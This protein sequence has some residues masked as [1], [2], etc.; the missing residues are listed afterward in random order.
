M[1]DRLIHLR[2]V[3]TVTGQGQFTVICD[4]VVCQHD[5]PENEIPPEDVDRRA[6]HSRCHRKMARKQISLSSPI[7]R[8]PVN[9]PDETS[10]HLTALR[11]CRQ[12]YTEANVVLWTT[13]TFSFREATFA[14]ESFMRCRTTHQKQLLRRLRLQ[15]E[16]SIEAKGSWNSVLDISV[17]RSLTGLKSLR[18]QFDCAIDADTY[19]QVKTHGATLL[20]SQRLEVPWV[21]RLA[22]LPLS[23]VEVFVSCLDDRVLWDQDGRCRL[24][25]LNDSLWTV[26]D[27][28][29][30]AEEIRQRLLNP[31]GAELYAQWIKVI[32]NR[33]EARAKREAH[34]P[35]PS[36]Q[37]TDP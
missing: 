16:S 28:A 33:K 27:R 36:I 32:Q 5:H 3:T 24:A 23:E 10:I 35:H 34:C 7:T 1:G 4:H 20:M 19:D 21:D 14:F 9:S 11:V 18:L 31:K 13:N 22:T 25:E 17:I 2:K 29:E 26:Q 8:R 6:S 15:V 30:Y 37:T 12:M